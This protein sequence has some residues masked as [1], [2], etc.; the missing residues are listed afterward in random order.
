VPLVATNPNARGP[1]AKSARVKAEILDKAADAF[2]QRGFTGTSIRE[3]ALAVGMTQQG[4]THHFPTKDALLEAVLQ[5]R[6]E[7][8]VDHYRAAGLSVMDTLRAVVQDNLTKPGL[9]RLTATLASEAIDPDHPAHAFFEEHFA[10]A[11]D[12]FTTLLQRGQ[13]L[14]EVRADL[15]A[16]GLAAVLLSTYEGLQL[17]WMIDPEF[18]LAARFETVIRMLE[19]PG[20]NSKGRKV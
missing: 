6:D 8:A 3:I 14:G 15:P 20:A 7:I 9:V 4:L 11:R 16:E 2:A 5:R 13:K 10:K 19:P 1:Y 17:Q 18:D 12:V